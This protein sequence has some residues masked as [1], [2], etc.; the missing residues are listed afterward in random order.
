M[1]CRAGQSFIFVALFMVVLLA[2]AAVGITSAEVGFA[3]TKVQNAVD[4][5][6][7][8][9]AQLASEGQD[10]TTDQ[11]WLK[12]QNLG[13]QGML[14]ITDS[15]SVPNGIRATGVVLVPGG[16]AALF[17][18]EQFTVRETAVAAYTPGPAFDYALFQ[19]ARAP[20]A[21]PINGA[22]DVHGAV[23]SNG[24]VIINGSYCVRQGITIGNGGN[25]VANGNARGGCPRGASTIPYVPMPIWT[26]SQLTPP[27]A[28]VL[29]NEN[30]NGGA[31]LIGNYIIEGNAT[32]NGS[33]KVIG[34]VLVEGSLTVNG[35]LT[36]D[37]S[38]TVWNGSIT[39]NG[40]VR[41]TGSGGI[42]LAAVGPPNTSENIVIN[43]HPAVTGILY[44]PNGSI[45]FNGSCNVTGAVIGE[46]IEAI[47]GSA[48]IT[49]DSNLL[50]SVPVQSAQLVQ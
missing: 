6:A 30:V 38:L 31:T 22:L 49:Y 10:P 47:N 37:G 44:A 13:P 14:T 42:S 12:Q 9:G 17:G 21:I 46:T 29:T 25:F 20:T 16:F 48:T 27:N 36:M 8:A 34:R 26:R 50:T 19:G 35:G 43:G 18:I 5:A 40:G 23:H 45:T 4:S 11:A 39:L 1:R 2:A 3:Q 15:H 33:L 32:F 28:T 24:G 41:A 7:L